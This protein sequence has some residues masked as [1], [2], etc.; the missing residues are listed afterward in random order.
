MVPIPPD[1]STT[2]SSY[3]GNAIVTFG[4]RHSNL[5]FERRTIYRSWFCKGQFE[6]ANDSTE[7]ILQDQRPDYVMVYVATCWWMSVVSWLQ[8]VE[9]SRICGEIFGG[10]RMRITAPQPQQRWPRLCESRI[11][12][13][14]VK[15]IANGC[16][17]P[18]LSSR[19]AVEQPY[20]SCA[21]SNAPPPDRAGSEGLEQSRAPSGMPLRVDVI[22]H[23]PLRISPDESHWDGG[24]ICWS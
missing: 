19:H 14:E 9:N 7:T 1:T 3:F 18:N 2:M 22:A 12:A 5:A 23:F 10:P 24:H 15:T 8:S 6:Q 16:L 11:I 21:S 17:W 20:T 13:F 4:P